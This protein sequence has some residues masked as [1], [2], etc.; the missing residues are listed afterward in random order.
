MAMHKGIG[1]IGRVAL[2]ALALG[3]VAG[4]AADECL[5]MASTSG[6]KRCLDFRNGV[7]EALAEKDLRELVTLVARKDAVQAGKLATNHRAWLKYRNTSCGYAVGRTS[8]G[9]ETGITE[10]GCRLAETLKRVRELE[11]L[12]DDEKTGSSKS[13][14]EAIAGL[15]EIRDP[16]VSAARIGNR[17][18]VAIINQEFHAAETALLESPDVKMNRLRIKSLRIIDEG[19]ASVCGG[20]SAYIAE[21]GYYAQKTQKYVKIF[22]RSELNPDRT[23]RSIKSAVQDSIEGDPVCP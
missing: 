21:L 12:L 11:D 13:F 22:V 20:A 3:S 2:S 16:S 8:G 7:A 9:D 5:D 18:G 10:V 1:M 14:R 17:S 15:I 4:F 19:S 6:I 23:V